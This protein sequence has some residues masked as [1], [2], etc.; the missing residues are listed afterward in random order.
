[1]LLIVSLP[2]ND[3]DLARAAAEAGAD[4]VKVHMNVEHRASGTRFGTFAEEADTVRRILA[5]I[6]KPVGLMPGADPTALPSNEELAQLNSEGLAF[7]DIYTHHM[8]LRF[9]DL[10]RELRIVVAFSHFDGFVEP[11]FFQTHLTWPVGDG[12]NRIWMAEASICDPADYGKPFTWHDMR[13]I[14]I[15]QEYVDVPLI[16]PTQKAITPHDAAWLARDGA[17]GLM[18][19]AI[20]TGTTVDSISLA[21]AEFRRAIDA[22]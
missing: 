14:R 6:D 22:A 11:M 3:L 9:L 10:P 5:G 1:M 13:R 8:P 15:M 4:F 7:V 2:R 19:G 12:P 16:V 17:G 20:V 21:T 18:I